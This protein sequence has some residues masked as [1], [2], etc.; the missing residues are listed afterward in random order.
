METTNLDMFRGFYYVSSL[1]NVYTPAKTIFLCA[2]DLEAR[3]R[4]GL[5]RFAKESGWLEL[6]EEDGAVL[7]MPLAE[8]GWHKESP[9][10]LL[11]YT[12][13]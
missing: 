8:E 2:P 7:V 13:N 10:L 1:A 12:E 4:E 5:E 11:I 6:A 9:L 3:S